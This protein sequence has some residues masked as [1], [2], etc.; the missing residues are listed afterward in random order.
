MVQ[1]AGLRRCVLYRQFKKLF[2]QQHQK[3]LYHLIHAFWA[4]EPGFLAS[5]MGRH[6]GLPTLV[7]LV[8]GELAELKDIGYGSLLGLQTRRMVRLALRNADRLICSSAWMEK[9]ARQWMP[10]VASRLTRIPLGVN[11]A[12]FAPEG[13][14]LPGWDSSEKHLLHVSNLSPVKDPSLLLE[15]FQIFRSH[16]PRAR[17]HIV[18]GEAA[19]RS[20]EAQI[21]RLG[22]TDSVV[23]H[24]WKKHDEL[25]PYYRSADLLLMTSR[26][27]ATLNVA[28][29]ALACG[30]PVVSTAVGVIPELSPPVR[31]TEGRNAH[32]LA[33]AALELLEDA[34]SREDSQSP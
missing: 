14:G 28:L 12:L 11:L 2:Q 30:C 25:A 23:L 18:G 22:I 6:L 4:E 33:Q 13:G 21:T 8:G 10:E 17:L 1:K 7:S 32:L 26:Y 20:W 5:R 27:D 9:R 16:C 24:G 15:T 19:P 29:E 31:T 3:Q 34:S